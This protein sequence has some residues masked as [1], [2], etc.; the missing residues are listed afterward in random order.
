[1]SSFSKLTLLTFLNVLFF[2]LIIKK[3]KADFT[4]NILQI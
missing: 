2:N 4:Q 3:G 1:M